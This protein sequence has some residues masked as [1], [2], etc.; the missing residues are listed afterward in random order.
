MIVFANLP[1]EEDE[2]FEGAQDW[3]ALMA[4]AS[5][6]GQSLT[7]SGMSKTDIGADK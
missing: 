2:E 3:P 1:H 5:N 4:P 6:E 7:A